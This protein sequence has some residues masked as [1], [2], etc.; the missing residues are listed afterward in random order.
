MAPFHLLHLYVQLRL[1]AISLSNAGLFPSSVALHSVIGPLSFCL[2]SFISS[3][4]VCFCHCGGRKGKNA[5]CLPNFCFASFPLPFVFPHQIGTFRLSLC[6][7][8]AGVVNVRGIGRCGVFLL[9]LIVLVY[10]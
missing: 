3:F 9:P 7:A 5:A 10:L 4:T 2:L 8:L 6:G 1:V